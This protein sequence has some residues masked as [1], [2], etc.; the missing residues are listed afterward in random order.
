MKNKKNII[1]IIVC[2]MLL[3][4][5]L[6]VSASS[7]SAGSVDDPLVTKSYVDSLVAGS[8]GG[9][10]NL[11]VPITVYPGDIMIG[12]EG[13][14][15]IS[16]AE[17]TVIDN[18]N[19]YGIIDTSSAKYI[20]NGEKITKNTILVI[21]RDDGRGIKVTKRGTIMVKGEYEIR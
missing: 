15:I 10:N 21:P 14:E 13:T 8:E 6:V 7:N 4:G 9:G 11:F 5:T 1:S 16:T 17:G 18:G 12:G 20:N 19:G 3:L 2:A